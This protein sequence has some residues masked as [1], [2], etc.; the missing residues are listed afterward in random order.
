MASQIPPGVD[1][2]AIPAGVPPDGVTPNLVN[3]VN[4][5]VETLAV[6]AVFTALSTLFLVLRLIANWHRMKLADCEINWLRIP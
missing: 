6:G 2:C 3:P 1:L 5:S 4:L